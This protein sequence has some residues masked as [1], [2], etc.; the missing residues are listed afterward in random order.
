MY[1]YVCMIR[2]FDIHVQKEGKWGIPSLGKFNGMMGEVQRE[3]VD[4][5]TISAPTPERLEALDYVQGYPSDVLIL[6]SLKPTLLPEN[7]ALVRP[8]EG[9][10]AHKAVVPS[11]Y[12]G[13]QGVHLKRAAVKGC[14]VGFHKL[15]AITSRFTTSPIGCSFCAIQDSVHLHFCSRSVISITYL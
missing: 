7:M 10:M 9:N 2:R 3:E 15:L 11:V 4:F 5:C 12:P 1:V 6:T 13:S 14:I 8:L